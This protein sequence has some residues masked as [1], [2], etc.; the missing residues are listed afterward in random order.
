M[1]HLLQILYM[2][3]VRIEVL[4]SFV[5]GRNCE[6]SILIDVSKLQA[7]HTIARH[8]CLDKA[9]NGRFNFQ[10]LNEHL[11]NNFGILIN[12]NCCKSKSGNFSSFQ[13]QI[14]L[15]NRIVHRKPSQ[16]PRPSDV[17]IRID[18]TLDE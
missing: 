10:P 7:K 2:K 6:L 18:K 5:F 14:L 12:N 13:R 15:S 11:S 16:N 8:F 17:T 4:E 3:P 9:F 1:E